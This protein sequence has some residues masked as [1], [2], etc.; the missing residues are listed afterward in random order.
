[1]SSDGRSLTS[2]LAGFLEWTKDQPSPELFRRW[3]GLYTLG[4]AL[5][6]DCY[7]NVTIGPVYANMFVWLVGGPGTGKSVAISAARR[8][9][10]ATGAFKLTPQRI[11]RAGL[12]DSLSEAIQTKQ[13]AK[14]ISITHTLACFVPE[15]G[16]LIPEHD[17]EFLNVLNDLYDNGPIFDWRTRTKGETV[18]VTNPS[19]SYCGGTQPQFMS[20]LLPDIAWG[21]GAMSRTILVYQGAAT[22]LQLRLR[23]ASNAGTSPLVTLDREQERKLISD[24]KRIATLHGEFTWEDEAAE[25][26]EEIHKNDIPPLPDHPR[27]VH[28]RPRRLLHLIKLIMALSVDRR[29]DLVLDARA[30]EEAYNL[31]IDTEER[32]PQI[33]IEMRSGGHDE[34]MHEAWAYIF[35]L[36][37]Q[38]K[39][40]V[41]DRHLRHFLQPRIPVNMINYVVDHM[42]KAGMV[43]RHIHKKTGETL[44]EPLE[45]RQT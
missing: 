2:W 41:P 4:A 28:Y 43:E 22:K 9:A 19:F 1:M 24:L 44:W 36:Y 18:K 20:G 16:N 29:D 31:L 14:E 27:L 10:A 13:F 8:L 35:R 12:E 6:R 26:L 30:V 7:T 40:Y 38:T 11:T 3:A 37:R 42:E 34:H 15:L 5:Q 17:L 45:F 25:M 39:N 32:I 21:Q 33:F 23:T